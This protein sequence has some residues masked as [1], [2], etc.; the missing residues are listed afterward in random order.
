MFRFLDVLNGMSN[1]TPLIWPGFWDAK[2]D[3][4]YPHDAHAS[5]TSVIGMT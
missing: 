1:R 3:F 4:D 2:N 5:S